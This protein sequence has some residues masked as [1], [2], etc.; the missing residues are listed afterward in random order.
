[1]NAVQP[2]EENV[3]GPSQSEEATGLTMDDESDEET[4]STFTSSVVYNLKVGK[5]RFV[6]EYAIKVEYD[7][8]VGG[9]EKRLARHVQ[10]QT[11]EKYIN[12][13]IENLCRQMFAQLQTEKEKSQSQ[14]TPQN[15]DSNVE[16]H[17]N[18]EEIAKPDRTKENNSTFT[19]VKFENLQPK[20]K[21]ERK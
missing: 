17:S 13:H 6:R 14:T 20:I 19:S 1:M 10:T 9:H 8:F 12:E 18:G 15:P 5:V 16:P 7:A 21:P 4:P 3:A 11:D 2:P